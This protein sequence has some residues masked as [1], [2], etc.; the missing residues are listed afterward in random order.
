MRKSSITDVARLANV[1]TATVSRVLNDNSRVR[2]QLRERVLQAMEDLQYVPSGIARSM[3]RQ[4]TKTIG[5]IIADIRNPFFTE[6]VSA[7]EDAAYRNRY[8]V[9]LGSSDDEIE[10]EQL[11][12]AALAR[13]RISGLILVPVSEDPANY[14]FGHPMPLVFVDR[15]VPGAQADSVTLDNERGGYAATRYLIELGHRRIGLVATPTTH[16]VGDERRAGYVKALREFNIPVDQQ[17]IRCGDHPKEHGGYEA[18][19]ELM[20]LPSPPTALFAV[21]NVRTVGMLQAI[22]DSNL[23]LPDDLSVI[24]F[25]DSPWLSLLTPPLTTVRQPIYEIGSEAVRLLM[26][27]IAVGPAAPPAATVMQPELVVRNSTGAPRS[28]LL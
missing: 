4:S 17:L 6:M 13:E 23:R 26:Q 12:L 5:L 18:V 9:L 10:K 15:S 24:G 2:P 11:Y 27:R 20:A 21:N 3:R 19:Q 25:D 14:I 22:H 8:T 16:S 28:T 7:I 1:S